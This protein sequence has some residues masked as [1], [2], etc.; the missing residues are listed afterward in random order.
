MY[1]KYEN[2]SDAY[3]NIK[4]SSRRPLIV[5]QSNMNRPSKWKPYDVVHVAVPPET[6]ATRMTLKVGHLA[7]WPLSGKTTA[8]S[9]MTSRERC[10]FREKD[11]QNAQHWI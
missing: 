11:R 5:E 8:C 9:I 4:N 3:M 2:N 6:K 7:F 1:V 10:G